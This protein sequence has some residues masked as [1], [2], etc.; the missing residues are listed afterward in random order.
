MNNDIII[1]GG[2]LGGL[3]TGAFLS[4]EGYKVTIL[5]KNTTIGGGL[6]TFKRNGHTFDTGMHVL[7]GFHQGGTLNKIC[8]YLDIMDKLSIREEDKDCFDT[9]TYLSDNKTYKMVQGKEAFANNLSKYFPE[10]KDNIHNYIN[11]LYDLTQEV[12]FFY[13]KK[14]SDN[15]FSHSEQFLWP[16]DKLINYY[17]KDQK[18]RDILGYMNPMYGGMAGHTPAYIHAL[19]NVLY[20]NGASRFNDSSQQLANLLSNVITSNG[21]SI[22]TNKQVK[23]I[24]VVDRQIKYVKTIDDEEFVANTYISAIH[25]CALLDMMNDKA[26]PKSYRE[27]LKEIPNSYSAFSV[28]ITFKKDSFPYVNHTCYFQDDY[29]M[30]WKHGEYDEKSWP[31]GFM[32]DT[33]PIEGQGKYAQTMIINCIMSYDVVKQWAN[34]TVGKRGDDYIKWKQ[35]NIYKVL[36]KME[37]LHS[38]FK[39]CIEDVFAASPLTIRDYYNVKEGSLYGFRKDCQN[40][41]LSQVPIYTKVKNLLLTGQNINLHGICG[42]PLTAINTV[43]AIVGE[44]KLVDKINNK[45][46]ELYGND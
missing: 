31:K 13:L 25:P 2:G 43:E 9:I 44:N 46:K 1:I 6:Q 34:T 10:E 30:V 15:I 27:R 26:F 40:I 23:S 36:D 42:V 16:A 29:G 11:K 38:G 41:A 24:N 21:G 28:F 12:D 45:Y 19:I 35:R 14:G 4:K 39:D 5:E 7:G 32:Y 20:I 17:I 18:L 37:F 22:Y 3:F 33:P 8:T